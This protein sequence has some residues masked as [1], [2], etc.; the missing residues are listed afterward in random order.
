MKNDMYETATDY[1]NNN[2]HASAGGSVWLMRFVTRKIAELDVR[3][4]RAFAWNTRKQVEKLEA[5]IKDLEDQVIELQE[6][7]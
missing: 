5:R 4:L 6:A 3:T 1:R 2:D 7:K